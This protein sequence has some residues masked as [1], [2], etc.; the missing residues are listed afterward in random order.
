MEPSAETNAQGP[1]PDAGKRSSDL[2]RQE[3][4]DAYRRART[5]GEVLRISPE[6]AKRAY[7]LL[8]LVV[9]VALLF[10][11]VN[12]V[13]E[14]ATG[15]AM[16][17]F[18]DRVDLTAVSSGTCSSVEVRPGDKVKAGQVLARFYEGPEAAQLERTQRDFDLLLIELLSDPSNQSV[19][20]SLA[21][22]RSE[23]NWARSRLEEQ[24]RRAPA[25]GI[26][27]DVR[28]RPGQF[29]AAGEVFMTLT[30]QGSQASVVALLPGR[31]GPE[32]K[33]GM[34]LRLEL[35]GYPY[36]YQHLQITDVSSEVLGP[37]AARRVLG[38]DAAEAVQM[39][40]P[41][42]VVH[43]LLNGPT[44]HARNEQHPYHDGMQG[45]AEV[46]V[47]SERILV[48]LVP[49]LRALVEGRR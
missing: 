24:H 8:L 38:R 25:D 41:V 45:K 4:V 18:A 42:V 22:L 48:A 16:V 46:R 19:R 28:V 33:A 12:R 30:G 36:S 35:D 49:G 40:E 5:E 15:R 14:Y 39:A 9:A 47:R 21:Q 1:D 31:Y 44:F 23:R 43:A 11:L 37:T 32:L 10:S 26:V 27:A 13:H 7:W 2:F 17:R 34:D 3:A 6:W 29:V 20:Q